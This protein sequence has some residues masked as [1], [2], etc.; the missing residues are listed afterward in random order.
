M[1]NPFRINPNSKLA[2]C[3]KAWSVG[4][5]ASAYETAD[6]EVAKINTLSRTGVSGILPIAC[7]VLSFFSSYE[8]HEVPTQFRDEY[9]AAMLVAGEYCREQGWL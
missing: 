8:R 2:R 3:S 5:H 6:L 9:D 1:E 4:N 7:F